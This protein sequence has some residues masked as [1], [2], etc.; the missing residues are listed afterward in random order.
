MFD[1]RWIRDHPEAFDTGLARRGLA[2]LS[3]KIVT[4]DAKRRDAQ[5]ELQKLQARRNEASKQ[6]GIAKKNGEDA[7]QLITK[8]AELKER[9]HVLD[10]DQKQSEAAVEHAL[11]VI[12]N[13]PLPEVPDGADES[14]NVELRRIGQMPEFGYPTKEH[15]ELGEALSMMDFQNVFQM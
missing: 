8:V 9:M 11:Q 13:L 5:T 12:P 1:V 3:S 4:L 14:A 7:A 15:H 6:I 2:P 10:D